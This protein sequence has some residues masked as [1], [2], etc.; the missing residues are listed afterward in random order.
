MREYNRVPSSRHVMAV[1]GH[2]IIH[3][4]LQEKNECIPIK[5]A[6]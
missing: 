5:V 4:L 6:N 3:A 2:N 1:I